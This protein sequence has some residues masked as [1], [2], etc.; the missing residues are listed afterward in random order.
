VLLG[1]R[2][3]A[4]QLDLGHHEPFGSKSKI[5]PM[6]GQHGPQDQTGGRQN[7]AGDRH[8]ESNQRLTQASCAAR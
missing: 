8:L 7:D 5:R 2:H 3:S 4:Q 1:V 6:G